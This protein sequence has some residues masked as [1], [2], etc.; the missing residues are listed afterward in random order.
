MS[1]GQ[2]NKLHYTSLCTGGLKDT[3]INGYHAVSVRIVGL[4]N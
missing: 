3:V 4:A 2:L 1:L